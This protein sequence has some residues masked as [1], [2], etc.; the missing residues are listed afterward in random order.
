MWGSQLTN[1]HLSR[2]CSDFPKFSPN[3]HHSTA[4]PYSYIALTNKTDFILFWSYLFSVLCV[5]HLFALIICFLHFI[6]YSF[7]LVSFL[8]R[9]YMSILFCARF[10]VERCKQWSTNFA[11]IWEIKGW[12]GA[13][14]ILRTHMSG[15]QGIRD[16][17][18]EDPWLN[19]SNSYLD[20][21]LFFKIKE[22][23]FVK[24]NRGTSLISDAFISYDRIYN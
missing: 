6:Q 23:C 18:P 8:H 24:N 1:C 19:F 15:G 2:L 4:A 17:F 3:S 13:S 10:N 16:Q 5:G 7:S 21:Y 14:S 11:K 20:V 12:H 22:T 9:R